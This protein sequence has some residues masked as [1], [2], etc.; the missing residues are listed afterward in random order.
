MREMSYETQTISQTAGGTLEQSTGLC[1]HC[2][3]AVPAG[4][5]GF[6]CQGCET[7]YSLLNSCGLSEYYSL[8]RQLG[9]LR[10][11]QPVQASAAGFAYLDDPEQVQPVSEADGSVSLEFYLEGVHCAACIWLV[12]KLPEYVPGVIRARLNL[13]TSTARITIGASV[14]FEPVAQTLVKWGYRP[15]LVQKTAQG[16]A[17]ARR[18]QLMTLS[19]IGVAAFSAGNLMI[20]AVALYAGIEGPLARYFE[21]LS[22]LL[23]APA[24]TFSAWPFY[25]QAFSQVF[26]SRQISIDVPIA[27][28][29]ILGTLGGIWEL[30]WGTHQIYFDSLAMLVF[31]LLFSRYTLLR[32]QQ[33]VL[34]QDR[35]LSFYTPEAIEKCEGDEIVSVPMSQLKTGDRI[36]IQPGMRIPADGLVLTGESRLDQSVLTGEAFPVP[37]RAGDSVYCGTRNQQAALTMSIAALGPATRL[38]QI[39]IKAQANLEEKT[40]LVRLADRLARRFVSLVLALAGVLFV[41]FVSHPQEALVRV[42]ALAIISCPCALALATPL[43][44][45][46]SLKRALAR[47]FFVR[48]AESIE[49]LPDL[50][51]I[52]FDKTGTLTQGRFELIEAQGLSDPGVRRAVLALESQSPH[53]VARALVQLLL[54]QGTQV[55][56]NVTDFESLAGGGVSGRIRGRLW[57][58]YPDPDF[59]PAAVA[60]NAM[61]RLIVSQDGE[62]RASCVLGDRLRPEAAEVVAGLKASGY[63]IWL[64]SGDQQP[65]CDSIACQVGIGPEHVLARQ[66]PEAKEAFFSLHPTA[67]MVGDGINDMMAMSRAKVGISVQGSAEENLQS[68]DIY[69]AE[70]GIGQLPAL[71][72]HARLTRKMLKTALG[73]SLTYNLLGITAAVLG[74][75][76]PL[77][78]AI[79][80]P[81]SAFTVLSMALIGE[82]ILCKS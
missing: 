4:A 50:K 73:F 61:V 51:T 71:L 25:R 80:M 55:I 75:V 64:L 44:V 79:L 58:I 70:Q 52:V 68:A 81:L 35:L 13:A 22:L 2:Q 36:R 76:T 3:Q 40:R 18:E 53:P 26:H 67:M 27:L 57:K 66:S 82:K 14:R 46:L 77:V 54:E 49:R 20:L 56:A 72:R 21:W 45:Q 59:N 43:M 65:A 6:C 11:A 1:L 23:A 24:V 8:R 19:R 16:E 33:H 9:T 10:A 12:E 7:V 29:L 37:V 42:L 30:L 38:G 62:Q 28:S 48:K 5:E 39:L 17:L 41:S 47:G 63:E 34:R 69:L 78:A 15:H 60:G 74:L 31:L 32:T